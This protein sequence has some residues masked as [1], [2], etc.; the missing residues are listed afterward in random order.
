M[1][2]HNKFV[3][4]NY[5]NMSQT[6]WDI[7][8]HTQTHRLRHPYDVLPIHILCKGEIEEDPTNSI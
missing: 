2:C 4:A 6:A 8:G 7:P 1:L 3:A 5:S